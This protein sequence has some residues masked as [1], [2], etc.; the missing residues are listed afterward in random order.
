MADTSSDSSGSRVSV[1]VTAIAALIAAIIPLTAFI[2]GVYAINLEREKF[3]SELRLKYIDRVLDNSK[4]PT[5]KRSFLE[6]LVEVT[7]SSDLLHRW[8]Q[9]QLRNVDDI[10]TLR[11][12]IYKLTASLRSSSSDLDQERNR[13]AKDSKIASGREASLHRKVLG[14]LEEK[15][16]LE[17]KLKAAELKAGYPLPISREIGNRQESASDPKIFRVEPDD[18]G[19]SFGRGLRSITDI[20]ITGENFGE[21]PG[22]VYEV[23][24][25]SSVGPSLKIISWRNDEIRAALASPLPPRELGGENVITVIGITTK[26][27][28]NAEPARLM[29]QRQI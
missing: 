11:A 13:R 28:R 12:T 21:S 19:S 3:T 29:L 5:Y 9:R 17:E 24:G 2:N 8:A 26:D 10:A 14:D 25:Q 20:V 4:D 22:H 6:Y 16:S 7:E 23:Y 15:R 27:L 1:T 18:S